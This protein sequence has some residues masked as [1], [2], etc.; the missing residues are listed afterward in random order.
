VP[1][2]L[3]WLDNSTLVVSFLSAMGGGPG[4]V[5]VPQ[6]GS[7]A[8]SKLYPANPIGMN[9]VPTSLAVDSAGNVVCD[10]AEV[11]GGAIHDIVR[12][13]PGGVKQLIVARADDDIGPS[14]AV[15]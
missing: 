1:T 15:Y 5:R 11:L 8:P 14:L 13:T 7:T 12:I 4:L 6:D 10:E 9:S 2:A 3:A